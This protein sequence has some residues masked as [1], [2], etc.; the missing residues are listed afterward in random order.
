MDMY[1]R[2]D[3]SLGM[4][5]E[6]Y[7]FRRSYHCPARN[8]DAPMLYHTRRF[9]HE[10]GCVTVASKELESPILGSGEN[11]LMWNWCVICKTVRDGGS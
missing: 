6:R 1:G 10:D 3:I 2:H 9:V 8:C 7:C 11:I 5:L 4:F